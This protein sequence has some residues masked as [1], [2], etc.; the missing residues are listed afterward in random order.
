MLTHRG[1]R[2]KVGGSERGGQRRSERHAGAVGK[3]PWRLAS[4]ARGV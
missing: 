2:S 1:R 3:F 4:R